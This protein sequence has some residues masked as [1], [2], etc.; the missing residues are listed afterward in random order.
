MSQKHS[1]ESRRDKDHQ[2]DKPE[3]S[4]KGSDKAA[5]KSRESEQKKA[6]LVAMGKQ[7]GFVTYEQ[8]ND[9]MPE[10]IVSSDQIDDW[11]ST[12]G[13]EGIEVVDAGPGAGAPVKV[14][15]AR[16]VTKEVIE[17]EAEESEEAA[18]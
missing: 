16:A 18:E 6:K 17:E 1:K 14:A 5:E 3:K 12:L 8:V 4:D 13:D 10:D 15:S 7:K 11:L 9:A 2:S